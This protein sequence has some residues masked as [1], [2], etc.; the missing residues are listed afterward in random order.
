MHL[1]VNNIFN[2][3]R[4]VSMYTEETAHLMGFLTMKT[5]HSAL[6][7]IR[8]NFAHIALERETIPINSCV[9]RFVA[10][11]IFSHEEVPAF[12]RSGVD[13]YAI[14]SEDTFGA[15]ESVPSFLKILAKNSM[16]T[17]CTTDI[18]SG[19]TVAVPTGAQIP[20]SANAVVM[21]E[22]CEELSGDTVAINHAVAPNTNIMYKGDDC[23]PGTLLVTRGTKINPIHIGILAAAGICKL[24]VY[25]PPSV[26]IISTGDE[27]VG[28]GEPLPLGCIRDINTHM[29][30]AE[31]E[32]YG[33]RVVQKYLVKDLFGQ[34]KSAIESALAQADIVIISGGTSVGE[35]DYTFQ[36]IEAIQ[37]GSVFAHGLA[38]KPGKPT[39]LANIGGKPVFGL[40]G[41]SVSAYITYKAVVQHYL[42]TLFGKCYNTNTVPHLVAVLTQNVRSAPGKT[43]FQAVKLRYNQG[44]FLADPL[45][46][47]SGLI[48]H[49]LNSD[50]L[51]SIDETQEG[52]YAGET[53][54]VIRL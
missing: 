37:P 16:G 52:L 48:S 4:A 24:E 7:E 19:E 47:K 31:L 35:K 44:G 6:G 9:G 5:L 34:I 46:G 30:A 39:I 12:N 13:G 38:I 40:P 27:L 25:K 43:T 32:G 14:I 50:G 11:D 17:I 8:A 21:V 18:K 2:I 36:A 41:Q 3:I 54:D 23:K 22:Y 15:T 29:I 26:A 51:I 42:D 20:P 45:Y 28:I 33:C 10:E 53:V 49:L 1:T